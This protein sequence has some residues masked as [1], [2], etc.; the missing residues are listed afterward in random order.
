MFNSLTGT[1]A[2]KHPTGLYLQSSGI[3]WDIQCP[4]LSLDT[5]GHVG[6]SARV[7][8]WLYHREDQMKLFGFATSREREIFL[9]LMK[10]EGIGPKQALRILSSITVDELERALDSGD[11]ARLQSAPGIGTKTAQKMILALKGKLTQAPAVNSRAPSEFSEIVDAL[12]GM[13]FDKRVSAERVDAIASELVSQGLD[14]AS[15]AF[16]KEL[17]HRAIV[18]MSSQ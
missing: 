12:V 11:L 10:V 1:I 16:E 4:A 13:G 7:F 6:E 15:S 3:E 2:E 14:R 8:T 9:D 17:F 18:A 5:F